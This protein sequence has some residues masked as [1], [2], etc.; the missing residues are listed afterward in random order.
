MGGGRII[1]DKLWFY[2]SY[3]RIATD[4]TVPGMWVNRNAG[5]PNAWTVD[6]DKS[7][8]AASETLDRIVTGRVTWQATPRNKLNF[9]WQEQIYQRNF[10]GGGTA[11]TTIE[12]TNRDWFEPSRLQGITWSSPLTSRILL[13]A[14]WGTYQSRYRNPAPRIDG[15]HNDRMIRATGPGRRDPEPGLPDAGRRG[16]WL[17]SSLDRDER[18]QPGVDV[19]RDR[20]AQHEVRVPGRIQQSEPDLPV[21]QRG[22]RRPAARRRAEPAP[23]GD[24]DRRFAGAD[25][26]RAQPLARPRSTRRIS[27]PATG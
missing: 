25:Q 1:R 6:F 19:V 7:R 18:E 24:Y 20:R 21:L 23:A 16:R 3:R 17:Q 13:E 27:G 26:D 15:T 2:M 22:E 10:K 5:N 11:T 14:G 9:S 8:Q 12:A 4:N